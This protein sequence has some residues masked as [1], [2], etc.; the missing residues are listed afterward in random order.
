MA[1]IYHLITQGDWETTQSTTPSSTQYRAA[2]L[3]E[4]GFIHC[5]A[6]PEQMLRVAGR[7]YAGR[8]DMLS[9]EVDTELLSSEVVSEPSRSGEIY[10]HIYGPLDTAAVVRVWRLALNSDG[11]FSL[12]EAGV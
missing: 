7:L 6:S 11:T 12:A 3:A 8:A 9:L 2:S 4:E 5:S 10:P 1:I